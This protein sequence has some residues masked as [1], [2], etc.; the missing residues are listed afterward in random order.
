[1][2]PKN[3][4]TEGRAMGLR[5][6]SE[7]RDV[8]LSWNA[9][10]LNGVLGYNIYRCMEAEKAFNVIDFVTADSTSFVDRNLPYDQKVTYQISVVTSE[11]QSPL[12]D[13][14]SITPG[15]YNY[16]VVDYYLGL[17]ARLTYDGLHIIAISQYA[18]YPRAVAADSVSKTAWV[19]DKLGYLFKLSSHGEV[20]MWIDGLTDPDQV[21]LDPFNSVV[22]VCDSSR[23]RMARYDT[24]GDSL[25]ATRGFGE[26]RDISL[27]GPQGGCWVADTKEGNIVHLSASGD[28]EVQVGDSLQSPGAI[29]YFRNGGWLWVADARRLVRVWPD[30]NIE[31]VVNMDHP[32]LSVSLDQNTGD[33]WVVLELEDGI[34]NE[35][36]KLNV[37]G[38]ILMRV[39]GFRFVQS[40]VANDFNGGCIVADTGNN[41]IVRLSKDGE[42]LGSM[43]YFVSPRDISVE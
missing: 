36:L 13:S 41:R 19:I 24:T 21:V 1:M 33:F 31:K 8:T 16:W 22:W 3:P 35:V 14:V 28:R 9:V 17:V 12:S 27:A 18:P 43:T 29:A 30:G 26:V 11:Y 5:V 15:P 4:E 40:L 38:D 32:I 34:E 2:D 7:R 25:G 39:E 42:I 20:L 37:D 10:L 6:V 23:T